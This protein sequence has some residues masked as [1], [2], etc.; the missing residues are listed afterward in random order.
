MRILLDTHA[1]IW[2]A[3]SKNRLSE[4]A[5]AVLENKANELV[6]SAASA[7]EIATKV[8]LGRMPGAEEL[9]SDFAGRLQRAGYRLLS[10]DVTT[11]LRAGRFSGD[12]GDPIDRILAAQALAEDIPIVSIDSRLDVFCVRRIW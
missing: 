2:A 8:R 4:K 10:I 12:H 9:E 1:V 5:R 11:A 3:F 7:W 6:V